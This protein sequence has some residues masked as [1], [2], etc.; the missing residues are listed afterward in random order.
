L[1]GDELTQGDAV[2]LGLAVGD[3]DNDGDVDIVIVNMDGT[4]SILRNDGGNGRNWLIVKL[5]GTTSN[6]QG[7]GARLQARTGKLTQTAEVTTSGSIFSASD[8]RVHF[9]LGTATQADLDIRWPSGKVQ[10]LRGV[11]ANQILEVDEEVSRT[12][13]Q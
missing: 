4:P 9:G 1:R 5:R 3:L 8:S 13:R 12:G 10:A 2:G 6:R 11:S 7:L